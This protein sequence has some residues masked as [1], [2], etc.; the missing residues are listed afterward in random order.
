MSAPRRS[1]SPPPAD[2]LAPVRTL[3]QDALEVEHATIPPYMT[4][5]LSIEDGSN[6]EAAEI[7]RGVMLEEMLHL[8]LV[9]NV[10]NAVGGQPRLTD[11]DFVPVYPHQLPHTKAKF[12]VSIET[13][14][15]HAIDTFLRI[16]LPEPKKAQPELPP[17]DTLGQFYKAI[18]LELTRLCARYG[19]AQVFC[20]PPERQVPPSAYYGSGRIIEVTTLESALQALEEIVDQGEGSRGTIYDHDPA[21]RGTGREPA[22]FYRFMEIK[23]GRLYQ[24]GDRRRPTGEKLPVD[25]TAVHPIRANTHLDDYPVGSPIRQSLEEFAATYG[26]L[27]ASLEDAF[28]GNPG[29]LGQAVHTMFTLKYQAQALMRIPSGRKP[30]ETVGLT[31]DQSS[32][33]PGRRMPVKTDARTHAKDPYPAIDSVILAH[34]HEFQRPGVLTVRPGFQSIAGQVTTRPAIVVSVEGRDASR[35][36]HAIPPMIGGYPTDVRPASDDKVQRVRDPKAFVRTHGSRHHVVEHPYERDA[37]T[38]RTLDPVPAHGSKQPKRKL[39]YTAP[40]GA[41]LAPIKGPMTI[42][43][44]ASPD[45]GFTQLKA[46]LADIS[47]QL[48]V[49]LYEFG[50]KPVLEALLAGMRTQQTLSLVLDWPFGESPSDDETDFDTHARLVKALGKRLTY[51][52]AAEAHDPRV[53]AYVFPTAYHIKVAVKDHRSVWLSSGNWNPSNQPA[54][55]PFDASMTEAQRDEMLR[56]VARSD[57]DWHVIV[58]HPGLAKTLEAYLLHDLK[59]AAGVQAH[60]KP[61]PPKLPSQAQAASKAKWVPSFKPLTIEGDILVHPLLT[62]DAGDGNYLT[63]I[64]DLIRSAR[65]RLYIQ[66]QYIELPARPETGEGMAT[67]VDAVQAKIA[68]GVD[69][70]IITSEFE[71]GEHDEYLERL[72]HAGF[73]VSK[74]KIQ[75]GVHN[76]GFVVDSKVVAI[77]SQNWSSQGVTQNRDATLIIHDARAAQYFEGIF[78]HDWETLAR[79]AHTTATAAASV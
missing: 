66:T 68:S 8:T 20:G 11:P 54:I 35:A 1:S 5:W 43:C 9:A 65:E 69:V 16:E 48:T 26:D 76:K 3:L 49:G 67:L 44:H 39:A 59:V 25:Y 6:V 74:M 79:P 50:S 56:T 40:S 4:A 34:A 61:T 33:R 37:Q 32:Q 45:A 14:S 77:G 28:N 70:R 21:I 62:P 2:F 78:L 73:D 31:F 13:F 57:R 19:E 53:E 55:D 18:E 52:W 22:H 12:K 30:G 64:L 10:L 47:R 23:Y 75:T 71:T 17:F 58:T 63:A 42:V 36:T 41:S 60:D 27:L 24:K 7:V 38:G 15:E 29:R 51:A 72:V 46:F